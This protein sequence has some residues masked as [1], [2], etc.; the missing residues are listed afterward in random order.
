MTYHSHWVGLHVEFELHRTYRIYQRPH[1]VEQLKS[2]YWT[3]LEPVRPWTTYTV[4]LEYLE[5]DDYT[6]KK[7]HLF[8]SLTHCCYAYVNITAT[9]YPRR[10]RFG[11]LGQYPVSV[12]PPQHWSMHVIHNVTTSY[13]CLTYALYMCK[14]IITF[15]FQCACASAIGAPAL[16]Y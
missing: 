7:Y 10:G 11:T 5:H 8:R 2:S 12:F 9:V 14:Y 15:P 6:T 13:R 1:Q 3:T 4:M 16:W